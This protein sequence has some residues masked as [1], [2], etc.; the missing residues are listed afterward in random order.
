M[1]FSR[2]QT[3]TP[4]NFGRKRASRRVTNPWGGPNLPKNPAGKA[5]RSPHGSSMRR[6]RMSAG[7]LGMSYTPND[8]LQWPIEGGKRTTTPWNTTQAKADWWN[9]AVNAAYRRTTGLS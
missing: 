1:P 3:G 5:L 7:R 8:P 9:A 6:A 2:K 4:S